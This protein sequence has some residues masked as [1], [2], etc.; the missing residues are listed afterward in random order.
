V[1]TALVVVAFAVV[2]L[3]RGPHDG[4]VAAPVLSSVAQCLVLVGAVRLQLYGLAERAARTGA[5]ARDAAELERLALLGEVG[6]TVAHEV[7]NPLTGIRS[8]AQRLASDEPVEGE[9]RARFAA[10]IVAEVDRLDRFV[11]GMLALARGDG[12]PPPEPA[13]ATD[14]PALLDDLQVLVAA[15]AARRGVRVAARGAGAADAPRGPL[16]QVLL[17]LLLNAID[18]SPAGGTVTVDVRPAGGGLAVAVHDRGPGLSAEA[19]AH[20]FRPFAPGARG[21]GLGLAVARRVADDRGWRV[22]V[23]DGADG[24]PGTTFTLALP[25]APPA[26][27]PAA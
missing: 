17:N 9:R 16:A 18:H 23:A 22:T 7:R 14:V 19:R 13:S 26:P 6:A 25:A 8:L 10:L 12:A 11:G 5:L 21:T 3:T 15:R 2:A 24:V 20:L 4:A 1:R 27:P